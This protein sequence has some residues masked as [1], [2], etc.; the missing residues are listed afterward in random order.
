ME[1]NVALLV[2]DDARFSNAVTV[3]HLQQAGYRNIR[4]ATNA[5]Q[6]LKLHQESAA[7]VMIVDWRMPV[8][9]GLTLMQ[10]VR[11]WDA[12]QDR[13]T[14][15]IMLTAEEG[16]EAI[17]AA[18]DH[19]VDDFI[20]KSN[21]HSELTPRVYAA[22]RTTQQQ[23]GLISRHRTLSVRHQ[24]LRQNTWQDA[25]THLAGPQYTKRFLARSLEHI[26][27]RGG[28][29]GLV[30]LRIDNYQALSDNL[31]ESG[32]AGLLQQVGQHIEQ[33]CRPMDLVARLGRETFAVVCHSETIE[34]FQPGALKRFR[35]SLHQ[36]S[37]K[38]RSG[39][40][41]IEASSC[42]VATSS[43]TGIAQ[44]AELWHL[45]QQALNESSQ[46]KRHVVKNWQKEDVSIEP[47]R[48]PAAQI[49]E[50]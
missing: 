7:E 26:E 37:L 40:V 50:A 14:Y 2:V 13:F 39:F 19:G 24:S 46:T 18:F 4:C 11:D 5:E 20:C 48:S 29:I 35:H 32:V 16:P 44:L 8:T 21:L 31:P 47:P 17:Q 27:G 38:T 6:A 1:P 33:L 23:N 15:V 34:H 28:A 42:L 3:R 49:K 43:D 12:E 36:R 22:V 41:T 25:I 10:Q 30:L 45:A 9:D